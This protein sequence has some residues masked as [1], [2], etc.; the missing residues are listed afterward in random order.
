MTHGGSRPGSGRKK[1]DRT[2][3]GIFATSQDYLEAVVKGLIAPDSVRVAAAKILI[4]YEKAKQ[5]APV[6]SLPPEKLRT[7]T[8]RDIEKSIH[9]DFEKKAAKIREK[10]K[11]KKEVR[12]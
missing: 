12:Q 5:R 1:K 6:K 11:N 3:D 8:Q 9:Q 7:K 4:Q 2:P 10:F